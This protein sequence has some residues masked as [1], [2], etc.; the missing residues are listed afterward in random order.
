MSARDDRSKVS[1]HYAGPLTRLAG[2]ALDLPIVGIMYG[3]MVAAVVFAVNLVADW[4]VKTEDEHGWIWLGGLIVWAFCYH[5]L[6]LTIAGRT[7]G[8]ALAGTRVVEMHGKALAPG[9]AFIRVLVQ[10][11]SLL[12]F[13]AG[14]IPMIIGKPRRAMHDYAAHSAVVY[15]WGDRSAEV[16]AP[17]SRYLERRGIGEDDDVDLRG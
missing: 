12:F 11:F 14:Y 9:Q 7:A 10:P 5:W 4:E 2:F 17:L 8:K 16:P 1:G 3:L 15:D 6:S 13:G